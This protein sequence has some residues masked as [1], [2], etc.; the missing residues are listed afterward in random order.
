MKRFCFACGA[1]LLVSVLVAALAS[2]TFGGDDDF[3]YG[4][5]LLKEGEFAPDFAL[6]TDEN[7]DGMML[8][9]LRG[10]YV[11]LE[12]WRSTCGDCRDATPAM[13]RIYDTYAPRGL[14][15]VGVSF[16]SD[17]AEWRAYIEKN[18]LQWMQHREL[19]A[20]SESAVAAAYH[21]DWTPT[22][23]LVDPQ[24]RISFATVYVGEMEKRIRETEGLSEE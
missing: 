2:C 11:L 13:K 10:S 1:L 24:G 19:S 20:A 9:G 18:G 4:E 16:D 8:S 3:D 7:P 12:F 22:F 17:E 6:F 15:V 23:Y 5:K 21:I 14:V